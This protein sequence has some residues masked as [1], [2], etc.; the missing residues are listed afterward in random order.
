MER[1]LELIRAGEGTHFDPTLTQALLGD[2]FATYLHRRATTLGGAAG[3]ARRGRGGDDTKPRTAVGPGLRVHRRRERRG[4]AP[5]S[6]GQRS[7]S[8]SVESA[9]PASIPVVVM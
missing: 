4:D 2:A 3:G 7:P 1:V 5:P 8:R 6:G 9:S